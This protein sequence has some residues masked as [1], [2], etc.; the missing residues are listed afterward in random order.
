M[1]GVLMTHPVFANFLHENNGLM[2]VVLYYHALLI[3][4]EAIIPKIC[5]NVSATIRSPSIAKLIASAP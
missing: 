1:G 2:Y 5:I 3:L 4:S